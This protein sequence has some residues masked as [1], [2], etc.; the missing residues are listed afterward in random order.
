[1]SDDV[2]TLT[3]QAFRVA[4]LY[5]QTADRYCG[6]VDSINQVRDAVLSGQSVKAGIILADLC[7]LHGTNGSS[8]AA[9]AEEWNDRI[10]ETIQ[11]VRD[12]ERRD[13]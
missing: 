2:R 7:R 10:N 4:G 11:R 8:E 6:V 12:G 3:D 9:R 1:M 5:C 13:D